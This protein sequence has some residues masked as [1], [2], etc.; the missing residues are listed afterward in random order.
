DFNAYANGKWVAANPIPADKTRWG[1]FDAL[2]EQSLD[3]Q[4]TLVQ[5]A[6]KA[7]GKSGT[8]A[9]ESKIGWFF[10]AGMDEAAINK[11][12]FTP[13]KSDLAAIA[14]LDDTAAIVTWLGQAFASGDGQGFRFGAGAD[15]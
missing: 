1:A 14:A 8:S 4:H 6:E 15:Y 3:A 11:A 5:K 12:G 13:I 9:I 10:R 2:A 7:A